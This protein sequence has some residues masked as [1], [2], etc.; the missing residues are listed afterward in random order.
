MRNPAVFVVATASVIWL[1]GPGLAAQNPSTR[2]PAPA[3]RATA[4]KISATDREFINDMALA[5][6]TEIQLGQLTNEHAS[7]EDVKAFGQMMIRDHTQ[8][9]MELMRIASQLKAEPPAQLDAKHKELVD[10]LSKL[11][12]AAFDK[13]YMAAMVKGHHDVEDMLRVRAGI[14]QD[15]RNTTPN[16]PL[17]GDQ[18]G[19][20]DANSGGVQASTNSTGSAV[21]VGTSG[22]D[23]ENPAL[24]EWAAKTLP[25]VQQHLAR[26]AEIQ[27]GLK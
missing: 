8:S 7:S 19:V 21:A 17:S 26:A 20:R 23:D 6:R 25:T 12:G 11:Q 10:K 9:G 1:T 3:S 13:E 5:G 18:A 16:T 2:Q 4:A 27:K 22:S 14:Q 15:T 24:T